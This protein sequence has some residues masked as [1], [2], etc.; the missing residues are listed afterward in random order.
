MVHVAVTI[1]LTPLGHNEAENHRAI[2]ISDKE[3]VKVGRASKNEHKGLLA[4]S[5]NAWFDYPILSR[6]HAMFTASSSLRVSTVR[7]R[8]RLVG[9]TDTRSQEVY[10][11]DCEST[12]G[13]FLDKQK[14]EAGIEYAVANG[15]VITFGQKVT[16]GAGKSYLYTRTLKLVELI[17]YTQLHTQPRIFASTQTGIP[18]T[19]CTN[20]YI[21]IV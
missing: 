18:A 12:H 5:D 21:L 11:Q 16:S 14:L 13:T 1:K 3:Q 19:P 7:L 6:T 20:L 10:V 4:A 8:Q 9:M 15:E 17:S 2:K